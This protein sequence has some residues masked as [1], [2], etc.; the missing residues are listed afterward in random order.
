MTTM[1]KLAGSNKQHCNTNTNMD[2]AND[3]NIDKDFR[4]K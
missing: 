2:A 3:K 1:Y 4:T